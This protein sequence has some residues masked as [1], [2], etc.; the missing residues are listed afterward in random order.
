MSNGQQKASRSSKEGPSTRTQEDTRGQGLEPSVSM[1]DT[2]RICRHAG[3]RAFLDLGKQPPANALLKRREDTEIYYPL[4]LALCPTCHLVQ[5]T[6]VVP[7]ERL[8]RDYRYFS[9]VSQRMSVHF[10]SFGEEAASRFVPEG[11]LLVEIGSNDGIL[12]QH[13]V[14]HTRV[15]GVDPA[16][17]CGEAARQRGVPTLTAFFNPQVA[18]QIL[19]E[20]GPAHVVLGANVLA[21]IPDLHETVRALQILLAP[22]GVAI[23]EF[24][25]LASL[26][27]GYAFDTVYHEHVS[28][29][30]LE[31]LEWLLREY[32]MAIFES[33][34]VSEHGGSIRIFV[35]R[36]NA[37]RTPLQEKE[38]SLQLYTDDT[39]QKFCEGVANRKQELLAVLKGKR[40]V[41][42]TA[43]AKGNVLLN[44]YGLDL[45]Y[46]ADATPSKQ[47]LYTPGTHIPI[48]SPEE[49]R[50]DKPD[51]A[52]L[53]AWNHRDEVLFREK[54]WHAAGGRFILPLPK[55]EII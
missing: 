6:H 11:G 17:P 27:E 15:L 23:F 1:S 28:Y 7:A 14:G 55:V 51:Y 32:G 46:L 50:R 5:L 42:Y 53:L 20:H 24:P 43:P 38:D 36:G 13:L 47:G 35:K 22:D 8:F 16:E 48:V 26:F 40:V 21:H 49:F 45:P 30:S 33:R 52:L 41:G 18:E 4:G 29:L 44:Y 31:P 9:S 2:C 54:E 3:L 25:Y 39:L 37:E 10:K 12:L 19:T 34:L